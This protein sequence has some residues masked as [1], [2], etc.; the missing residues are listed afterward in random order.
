[1]TAH[2]PH[3]APKRD[4]RRKAI[5]AALEHDDYPPTVVERT[6]AKLSEVVRVR[7]ALAEEQRLFPEGVS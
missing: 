4:E 1:M 5:L 7:R 2:L 3:D 6:K